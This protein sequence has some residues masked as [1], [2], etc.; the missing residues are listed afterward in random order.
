[1]PFSAP[2]I[3]LLRSTILKGEYQIPGSFSPSCTKLIRKFYWEI[4]IR[5]GNL[6]NLQLGISWKALIFLLSFCSFIQI[7]VTS[8]QKTRM[9]FNTQ[10][11]AA[12][13]NRPD[14][15]LYMDTRS[16]DSQN[17]LDRITHK[18]HEHSKAQKTVI[19]VLKDEQNITTVTCRVTHAQTCRVHRVLHQKVQ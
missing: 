12:S 17:P 8:S 14:S 1:M 3:P 11:T 16:K 18:S 10:S 15:Q 2:T 9:H 5:L 4:L 19:L 6:R 13:N 7:S